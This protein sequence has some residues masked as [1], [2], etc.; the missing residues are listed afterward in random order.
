[1]A[2]GGGLPHNLPH[3]K[4]ILLLFRSRHRNYG[5]DVL[6]AFKPEVKTHFIPHT[7]FSIRIC[8]FLPDTGGHKYSTCWPGSTT[9]PDPGLAKRV[10]TRAAFAR[11]GA[12][13]ILRINFIW[14]M[15]S[16]I[17]TVVAFKNQIL[18][19][20]QEMVTCHLFFHTYGGQKG[21]TG[22][23]QAQQMVNFWYMFSIYCRYNKW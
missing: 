16:K 1:M 2:E 9:P 19:D 23:L 6:A 4:G 7:L 15:V 8:L 22:L 20:L 17:K 12:G 10:S 13:H 14:L 21:V 11:H 18:W 5:G 3:N